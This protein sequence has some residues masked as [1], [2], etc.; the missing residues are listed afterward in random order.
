MTDNNPG[1]SIKSIARYMYE[2]ELLIEQVVHV[3]NSAFPM[4]NEKGPIFITG[5]EKQERKPPSTT[6][7]QTQT[8]LSN[9]MLRMMVNAQ[10]N[11]WFVL[12]PQDLPIMMKSQHP[13]NI[14]MLGV[15]YCNGNMR[16][17]ISHGL[18]LST[19]ENMY[20]LMVAI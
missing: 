19:T 3:D 4:Q 2:S 6:F 18:T 9:N 17:L 8:S 10:N 20:Y 1:K 14:I 7:Q 15:G 16:L 5:H 11:H 13:V 12:S